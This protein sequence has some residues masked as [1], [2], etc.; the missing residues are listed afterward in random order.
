MARKSGALEG[1]LNDLRLQGRFLD[2]TR[3]GQESEG[4]RHEPI[5]PSGIEEGG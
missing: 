3:R 1:Y 5:F 2:V 4:E